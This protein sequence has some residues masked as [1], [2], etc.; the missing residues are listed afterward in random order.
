MQ[1]W[2]GI[3]ACNLYSLISASRE[4]ISLL[5]MAGLGAVMMQA[6]SIDSCVDVS[7][8]AMIRWFGQFGHRDDGCEL[9]SKAARII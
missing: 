4:A 5:M 1:R 7:E 6:Q 2:E 8:Q 3:L 9:V